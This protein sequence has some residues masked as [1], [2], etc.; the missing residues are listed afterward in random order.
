MSEG[1]VIVPYREDWTDDYRRESARIVRSLQPMLTAIE[2]IGS[3]SIPQMAAQPVVDILAGISNL[4]AADQLNDRLKSIGYRRTATA[5]LQNHR[6]FVK[7][8]QQGQPLFDLYLFDDQ[9]EDAIRF[10]AFRDYLRTHKE[11]AALYGQIKLKLSKTFSSD[12]ESYT[13][14][15]RAAIRQIEDRAL[16]WWYEQ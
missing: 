9:T 5:D 15:K 7:E 2:H 11:D 12:R 14:A 16:S 1:I 6:F 13:T 10:L 8:N 4:N 3:T